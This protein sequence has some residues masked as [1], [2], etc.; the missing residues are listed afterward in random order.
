MLAQVLDLAARS[1]VPHG[2]YDALFAR[3]QPEIVAF[4]A[5]VLQSDII[6][7]AH[8][9]SYLVAEVDGQP[10]AALCGYDPNERGIP[11][12]LQ[13]FDATMQAHN[14]SAAERASVTARLEQIAPHFPPDI[15]DAW[16][17]ESV[18][19]LPAFRRQGLTEALLHQILGAGRVHGHPVAQLT[20]LMGNTPAQKVYEKV[21]FTVA[22]E[23][24]HP[25]FA[26]LIG[27]PGLMQMVCP[28][29]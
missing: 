10:A 8:Y 6:S 5:G 27:P 3:P 13:A 18:A 16:V 22:R 20:T 9:S 4:C 29:S 14:W 12:L 21:G 23:V 19:T 17:I 28:L 1:H 11:V 25:I 15:P 26:E 24:E 2:L 7:W